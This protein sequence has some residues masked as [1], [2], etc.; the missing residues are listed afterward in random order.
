MSAVSVQNW[1]FAVIIPGAILGAP[2]AAAALVY[3]RSMTVRSPTPLAS[4][5]LT[6]QGGADD[7]YGWRTRLVAEWG[8]FTATTTAGLSL[9]VLTRT[10]LFGGAI[11]LAI[12]FGQGGAT[13][14]R[15]LSSTATD[16]TAV[17][18][19]LFAQTVV[20]YLVWQF[21][22][23]G[24]W[25]VTVPVHGSGLVH[26][27]PT[28]GRLSILL[29]HPAGGLFLATAVLG[30]GALADRSA[31]SRRVPDR[32]I[33]AT[34]SIVA[35]TAYGFL[36][37]GFVSNPTFSVVDDG[38]TIALVIALVAGVRATGI[39]TGSSNDPP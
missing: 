17:W 18:R 12:G 2:L 5:V 31:E 20:L 11:P 19:S 6:L 30:V 26:A 24:L 16:R 34:A 9:I 38:L 32:A 4:L 1:L 13:L 23:A 22:W 14:L 27:L 37:N 21:L 7:D 35:I 36:E 33:A 28:P 15:F 39:S 3:Q 10:S 25:V 8:A 29:V